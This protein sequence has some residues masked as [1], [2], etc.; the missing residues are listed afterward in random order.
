ML[1]RRFVMVVTVPEDSLIG[2][3][4]FPATNGQVSIGSGPEAQDKLE[5]SLL[6]QTQAA[7]HVVTPTGLLRWSFAVGTGLCELGEILLGAL[8][9]IFI[10]PFLV[11]VPFSACV[12]FMPRDLVI[13][14][15]PEST[16]IASHNG[17]FP[18]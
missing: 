4:T 12:P 16:G 6:L 15:T 8:D 17:G 14:A 2:G 1:A 7:L 13:E 11:F 3:K 5:C 9:R 10:S 18:C